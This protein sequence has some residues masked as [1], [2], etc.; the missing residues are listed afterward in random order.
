MSHLN[1]PDTLEAEQKQQ[2]LIYLLLL[3]LHRRPA[4]EHEALITVV[5]RHTDEMEVK[6]M[7]Q[8]MA[9]TLIEQGIEQGKA[10]GIEQESR[11]SAIRHI[12]AVLK[13]KFSPDIVNTLTPALREINEVERL[14]QL[15]LTAVEVQ[16]LEAF[17]QMLQE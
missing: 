14:E 1:T 13:M 15:L 10:Q 8:S 16:S 2:A 12:L 4:E 6:T 11:A 17:A 9:E 7:A 3:I 5:D